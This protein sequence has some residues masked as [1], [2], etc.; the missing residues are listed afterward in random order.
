MFW[1]ELINVRGDSCNHSDNVLILQLM[2]CFNGR[3]G[4]NRYSS[5]LEYQLMVKMM[6]KVM[7]SSLFVIVG[8]PSQI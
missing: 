7:L 2:A 4:V 3:L 6:L 1:I 5:L 8:L